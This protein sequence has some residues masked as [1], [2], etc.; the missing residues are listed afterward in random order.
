MGVYG[1]GFLVATGRS[2][3]ALHL[4]RDVQQW[5][6]SSRALTATLGQQTP[7]GNLKSRQELWENGCCAGTKF[8]YRAGEVMEKLGLGLEKI[9]YFNGSKF[10]PG[11]TATLQEYSASF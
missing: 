10:L 6:G 3:S 11:S 2:R 7:H 9:V 4:S 1:Q 5:G 8:W